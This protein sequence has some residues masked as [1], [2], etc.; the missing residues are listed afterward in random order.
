LIPQRLTPNPPTGKN[1]LLTYANATSQVG[2]N[3]SE[4][5]SSV[6]VWT[7]PPCGEQKKAVLLWIYGGGKQPLDYC[8]SKTS[9]K[10]RVDE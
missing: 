5:S 6:N 4:D 8:V 7:K 3:F 1:I 2:H 10:R 9:R